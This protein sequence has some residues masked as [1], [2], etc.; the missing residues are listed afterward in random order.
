MKSKEGLNALKE[1][2]KAL[3]AKLAELT[4]EDLAQVSGG[5]PE[6]FDQAQ[7]EILRLISEALANKW[8]REHFQAEAER[9]LLNTPGLDN[10]EMQRLSQLIIILLSQLP[11]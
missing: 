7:A 8:T 1:D 5:T 4:E 2:V 10:I 9:V 11:V 6:A 3:S